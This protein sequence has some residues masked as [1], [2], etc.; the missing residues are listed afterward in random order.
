MGVQIEA[1]GET[2]T[3][4]QRIFGLMKIVQQS[5]E[6]T[7]KMKKANQDIGGYDSMIRF[8]KAI[9]SDQCAER[10][11]AGLQFG[12]KIAGTSNHKHK[13]NMEVDLLGEEDDEGE[14][15]S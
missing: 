6:N 2:I 4:R 12:L 5:L 11:A 13:D 1:R 15:K 8:V 3:E 9:G 7:L 14:D 10:N